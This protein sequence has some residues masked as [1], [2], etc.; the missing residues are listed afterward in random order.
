[1]SIKRT[2]L[3][4]TVRDDPEPHDYEGW[5]V[6]QC[7][8]EDLANGPVRAMALDVLAEWRMAESSA[9]FRGWLEQGAPSDDNP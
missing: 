4:H 3:E 2:L 9:R 5:L 6:A 1:M 7:A 8:N